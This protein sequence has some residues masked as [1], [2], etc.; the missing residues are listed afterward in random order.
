MADFNSDDFLDFDSYSDGVPVEQ[1]DDIFNR[2]T[3]DDDNEQDNA[4]EKSDDYFSNPN[5]NSLVSTLLKSK[6]IENPESIE[7][8]DEEGNPIQTNFY[9]LSV[10]EQLDILNNEDP[11]LG[12]EEN[13]IST[14]N[15]LRENNITLEEFAQYQRQQAIDEYLANNSQQNYVVNDLSDAELYRFDLMQKFPNLTEE[16]LDYEVEKE[17]INEELFAKKVQLLRDS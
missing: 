8:L 7:L 10:E 6:G 17:S 2:P 11:N 3:E 5:E 9:D 14:I 4:P 13:E 1:D 12:L 16:E 15:F